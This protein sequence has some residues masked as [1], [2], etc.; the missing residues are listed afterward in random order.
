[1]STNKQ[2]RDALE[3][4]LETLKL[5]KASIVSGMTRS[6]SGHRTLYQPPASWH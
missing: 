5:S 4:L 6:G 2:L 1:M 3:N